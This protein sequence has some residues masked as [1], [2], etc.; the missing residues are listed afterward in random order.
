MTFCGEMLVLAIQVNLQQR[1]GKPSV[2]LIDKQAKTTVEI[3]RV[4]MTQ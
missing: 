1:K 3:K 2:N 4:S